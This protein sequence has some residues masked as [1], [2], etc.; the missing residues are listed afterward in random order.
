MNKKATSKLGQGAMATALAAQATLLKNTAAY[1]D[2]F[3]QAEKAIDGTYDK[4]TNFADKLFPFSL[5]V[6]IIAILFT[7]D[8]K[9]LAA[10]IKTAVMICIAYVLLLIVESGDFLKT[11]SGLIK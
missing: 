7:H 8:Q 1:S 11:F 4:I 2:A 9:A 5:V 6:L 10:E 3:D